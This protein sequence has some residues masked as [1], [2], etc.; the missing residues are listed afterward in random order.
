MKIH[1][2]PCGGGFLLSAFRQDLLLLLTLL[3][4]PHWVSG[5]TVPAL[6]NTDIVVLAK[7]GFGDELIIGQIKTQSN[8]FVVDINAIRE[9][10]KSGV[11]ETVITEMMA[12]AVDPKLRVVDPNDVLSPHRPGIYYFR[13]SRLV[14]FLPSTLPLAKTRGNVLNQVTQGWAK[15]SVVIRMA[16]TR[17]DNQ[18]VSSQKLYFY[19]EGQAG[20]AVQSNMGHFGFGPTA[21]PREFALVKMLVRDGSRELEIAS[22]SNAGVERGMEVGQLLNFN[23]VEQLATGV[24]EVE[25]PALA[26]GEYCIVHSR[27]AS[28]NAD[29]HRVFDFHLSGNATPPALHDR[30]V[31]PVPE[32]L[33]SPVPPPP[34]VHSP[35]AAPIPAPSPPP[36]PV[37]SPGPVPEPSPSLGAS[38]GIGSPTSSPSP[39]QAKVN[40]SR[41]V[42]DGA[43]PSAPPERKALP[44]H[45]TAASGL[46]G[47]VPP[48]VAVN[49]PERH[50][51][52]SATTEITPDRDCMVA[53]ERSAGQV[54]FARTEDVPVEPVLV[55]TGLRLAW[56]AG[57]NGTRF[58]LLRLVPAFGH[59]PQLVRVVLEW[60]DGR[61]AIVAS[62]LNPPIREERRDGRWNKIRLT[63][64]QWSMIRTGPPEAVALVTKAGPMDVSIGP[65]QRDALLAGMA[66]LDSRYPIDRTPIITPPAQVAPPLV[67]TPS[68]QGRVP[69]VQ[70]GRSIP[71]KRGEWP[72]TR[73]YLN[74]L[75]AWTDHPYSG[76]L[77]QPIAGGSIG[78]EL[79][80]PFLVRPTL[81]A[82][83]LYGLA[84]PVGRSLKYGE[85]DMM[86]GFLGAR[87]YFT[88]K[89]VGPYIHVQG[90]MSRWVRKMHELTAGYYWDTGI[91]S[92][93]AGV[94]L[95]DRLDLG[96]YVRQPVGRGML[97]NEYAM[98]AA[99]VGIVLGGGTRTKRAS[100]IS[101][102][103]HLEDSLGARITSMAQ[104]L[105]EMERAHSRSLEE[106]HALRSAAEAAKRERDSLAHA[107]PVG[108][109]RGMSYAVISERPERFAAHRVYT[110]LHEFSTPSALDT[111]RVITRMASGGAMKH[112]LWI[113]TASGVSYR[114]EFY[115]VPL[116]GT[117]DGVQDVGE[118]ME[119]LRVRM[120]LAPGAFQPN[121]ISVDDWRLSGARAG[122][123]LLYD[124]SI[125]EFDSVFMEKPAIGFQFQSDA[126]TRRELVY[127]NT[128]RR[129]VNVAPQ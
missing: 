13:E 65:V 12:A 107:V 18:L 14:E 57:V 24:F 63:T 16:G 43:P 75:V 46:P 110:V 98:A 122:R 87:V 1:P 120:A 28:W 126:E 11:S 78:L 90:G 100:D 115:P 96:V 8:A 101:P 37:P 77:H 9:L 5:Q 47:V 31:A 93:G 82:D 99:R 62:D 123:D 94:V 54:Q 50:A 56:G 83:Y 85:M 17:S 40:N 89:L 84:T 86:T 105:A 121:P 69:R 20:S 97:V 102:V 116:E 124:L 111:F 53:E 92:A 10:K 68:T 88:R 81:E 6:T 59:P 112:E 119:M 108:S 33:P 74:A 72:G 19:F 44:A 76:F 29:H 61:R 118:E 4:L 117:R 55:S 7:E 35:A 52:K 103:T 127:S 80:M 36:V 23:K 113:G 32:P 39:P 48:G 21:N 38:G 125:A 71:K 73:G 45:S 64:E 25:L 26:E 66:C 51:A 60:S 41:T 30:V 49:E 79:G 22:S 67:T 104:Q 15:E 2:A 34:P 128:L 3:L 109:D 106:A 114:E 95:F 27:M 129:I 91:I 42:Q 58:L 70:P